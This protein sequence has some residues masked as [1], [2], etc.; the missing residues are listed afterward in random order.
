[1]QNQQ[2]RAVIHRVF[3]Q[4]RPG[5]RAPVGKLRAFHNR[6]VGRQRLLTDTVSNGRKGYQPLYS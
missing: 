2:Q 3:L 5:H 1:M 6:C 4:R